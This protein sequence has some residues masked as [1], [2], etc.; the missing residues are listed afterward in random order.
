[1]ASPF[2]ERG[3]F[4][5]VKWR[6]FGRE[7]F[8]E[9]RAAGKT[10]LIYCGESSAHSSHVLD[11]TCLDEESVAAQ[12]NEQ[13]VAVR[14]DADMWPELAARLQPEGERLPLLSVCDAD[15]RLRVTIDRFSAAHFSD[16]LQKL[17]TH[18]EV[19]PPSHSVEL[20]R[21]PSSTLP[22]PDALS[23]LK[24]SI[25]RSYDDIAPGFGLP[26]RH[27]HPPLLELMLV[28]GG[29]YAKRA[30]AILAAMAEGGIHDQLCG[31]FHRYSLDERFTV[32]HFEKRAS[33][34]AAL[35]P[36]YA[37]LPNE[38]FIEVAGST[39]D[40]LETR[41]RDSEGGYASSES[42]DAGDYDDGSHYTFSLEEARAILSTEDLAVAQPYY[43]LYERGELP[44]DPTR[45]V[46]YRSGSL[47]QIAKELRLGERTVAE[48]LARVR[49]RLRK[50]RQDRP[51]PELDRTLYSR[52]QSQIASSYLVAAGPLGRPN[53]VTRALDVLD[54]I[55]AEGIDSNGGV[56]R[57]LG[58]PSEVLALTDQVEA[59]RAAISAHRLTGDGK[60]RSFARSLSDLI[61]D[62]FF[63]DGLLRDLSAP[64]GPGVFAAPRWPLLDRERPSATALAVEVLSDT[65]LLTGESR[66]R[67]SVHAIGNA[68]LGSAAELGLRGAGL[69]LTLSR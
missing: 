60:H 27:A 34:Q 13:F 41:L 7:A 9:A 15:G 56:R 1:M 8:A 29:P 58:Q 50:A 45:N 30:H 37:R 35:I 32:P 64:A 51:Q 43:D 65:A 59:A 63:A 52:V 39:V 48:R 38:R 69:L 6:A 40:Y 5:A 14:L 33:D 23:L 47:A 55:Y 10:L 2:I 42:A 67:S 12:I 11:T 4:Q 44:R 17:S 46:L 53:L 54:R 26:P 49:T 18:T 31:G 57:V 16:L 66:Y 61:C 62:R 22:I 21:P 19:A 36:L 25:D 20:R 68:A 3:R 24:Q 28:L